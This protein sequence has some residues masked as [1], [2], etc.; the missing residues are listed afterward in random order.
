M[1]G[2][3]WGY[4]NDYLAQEIFGLYPDYGKEGFSQ[5]QLARK[6]DPFSDPEISELIWDVFCLIHSADWCICGDNGDDTYQKDID[7]FKKKW[8]GRTHKERVTRE[9]ESTLDIARENLN[10][11]FGTDVQHNPDA[12]TIKVKYF[13][14]DLE[15]LEKISV[16]DW[17][18]LRAAE[19]VTLKPFEYRLIRLG[20]GMILPDGYEAHVLPRS[21]TPSKFG[22]MLANSMGVIDNSYSGDADEWHFPAVAIRD[23]VIHKGD[24]IAQFR[25]VKNQPP[26]EF[27]VVKHLNKISRGGIG[28]TGKN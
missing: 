22:I 4:Q 18:D 5:S 16:G 27:K 11:I 13:D 10:K 1:S 2:G 17:I 12:L 8:F 23:T 26:L 24:R 25:I 6:R 19:T 20:I 14:P 21:S 3:H 28:S 9:I 7:H 15:P